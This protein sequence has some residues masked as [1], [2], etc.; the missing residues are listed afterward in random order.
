MVREHY[1][2]DVIKRLVAY[3][4]NEPIGVV[5]VIESENYIELDGFGVLE[6]FRHQGIGSTMQSITSEYAISRD[7]KPVILVADGEDTAKDMYAKQGYV[8][9]IRF[10][11]K[12]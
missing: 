10:V 8:Y 6:Q 11:I 12:Y 1:Q 5:D 4:N 2:K 7:H 3:S 9:Q